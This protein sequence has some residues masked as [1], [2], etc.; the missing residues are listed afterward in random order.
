MEDK[1][2]DKDQKVN[3][4]AGSSKTYI[5]DKQGDPKL[6]NSLKVSQI[7]HAKTG[8][9]KQLNV[10]FTERDAPVDLQLEGLLNKNYSNVSKKDGES[11]FRGTRAWIIH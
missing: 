11:L 2:K 6:K 4:L 8:L 10:D 1:T 3:F 5:E 7:N 9:N